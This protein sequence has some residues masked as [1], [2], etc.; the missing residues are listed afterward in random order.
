MQRAHDIRTAALKAHVELGDK[1]RLQVAFR[2][3]PW[4]MR[5]LERGGWIFSAP[6]E[7]GGQAMATRPRRRETASRSQHVWVIMQ[8][9]SWKVSAESCVRAT[10]EEKQVIEVVESYL[11]ELKGEPGRKGQT[12][13][14]VG[15]DP[16]W[17]CDGEARGR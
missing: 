15:L 2:A 13:R 5:P 1:V 3:R 14:V 7:Q 4:A 12:T 17:Y 16:R 9:E 8:D 10:D 6:P 11:P